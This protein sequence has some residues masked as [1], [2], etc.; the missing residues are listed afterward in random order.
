MWLRGPSH[1]TQPTAARL[2][3][4]AK[5]RDEIAQKQLGFQVV[6]VRAGEQNKASSKGLSKQISFIDARW[7]DEKN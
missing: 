7:R 3:G 1:I 2:H 5:A 4:E 6:P